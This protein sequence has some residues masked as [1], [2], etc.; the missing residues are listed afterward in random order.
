MHRDRT[1]YASASAPR[2]RDQRPAG[3]RYGASHALQNMLSRHN[4]SQPQQASPSA[5][6]LKD[7]EY[8][9]DEDSG[10]SSGELTNFDRDADPA[11]HSAM[12]VEIEERE[13]EHAAERSE[14]H[15]VELD[16]DADLLRLEQHI[17]KPAADDADDRND[18]E[19]NLQNL[20]AGLAETDTAMDGEVGGLPTS[21]V[22]RSGRIA[23]DFPALAKTLKG[24]IP[25]ASRKNRPRRSSVPINDAAAVD[26]LGAGID[27]TNLEEA[28]SHLE[29]VITKAD[30]AQMDILG[31]FNLGF[32]IARRT[33]FDLDDL[34]II[35][36][37]AADEKFNFETLQA[38]T[39]IRSQR[40]IQPRLL[41]LSATDE[42]VA[43]QHLDAIA[44]N[45]FELAIDE[46]GVAG[47]RVHLIAQPVSK[48]TVF[49]VRDLEELLFH[50]RNMTPGS[51]SALSVRCSKARAMFASRA[52]RKS[53]MIGT[54]LNRRQMT[55]VVKHMGTIEQPWNCPH[56]RPTM[57]HLACL[58]TLRQRSSQSCDRAIDW[59]RIALL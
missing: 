38:Q 20:D 8:A 21:F 19:L 53:V 26:L 5:R 46:E 1:T 31:Q 7:L 12:Q 25:R 14:E 51:A 24:R 23:L 39:Q 34:F 52:C 29:R 33:S 27:N 45:G 40:L 4:S 56:G 44:A 55:T 22:L 49:G 30:F 47:S 28:A 58:R 37:H 50:L 6:D 18:R 35:D 48:D 16:D 36:Q 41:E 42:L 54:A 13:A 17:S 43:S 10:Q 32:I 9:E 57:R 15:D 11:P 3:V 59:S 2:Q